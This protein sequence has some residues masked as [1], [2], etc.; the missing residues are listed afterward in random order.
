MHASKSAGHEPKRRSK[1]AGVHNRVTWS[2]NKLFSSGEI[3][4]DEYADH[5]KDMDY[6]TP[7]PEERRAI[8]Q[9]I[10]TLPTADGIAL[11][12]EV[13]GFAYALW[14]H[15][16]S[17]VYDLRHLK[18]DILRDNDDEECDAHRIALEELP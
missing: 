13:G 16:V 4:I 3:L 10:D 17:A 5:V 8:A 7:S 11:L 1:G 14:S 18:F 9:Q 2:V 12:H 15:K 6:T